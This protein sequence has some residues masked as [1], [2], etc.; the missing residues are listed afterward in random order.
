MSILSGRERAGWL[1]VLA[2]YFGVMVGFGSMLVFTFSIF[3]KPVAAEF[4]QCNADGDLMHPGGELAA[5]LKG[6]KLVEDSQERL[7]RHFFNKRMELGLVGRKPAGE[8][9]GQAFLDD[10]A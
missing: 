2:A 7:L 1:V 9:I 5:A 3:L 8:G 4:G 10:A 6:L